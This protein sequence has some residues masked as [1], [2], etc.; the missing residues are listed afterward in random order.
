LGGVRLPSP[1]EFVASEEYNICMQV[2]FTRYML[3][4]PD[5]AHHFTGQREENTLAERDV[6]EWFSQIFG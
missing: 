4:D 1:S 6:M 3:D 5:T 2:S